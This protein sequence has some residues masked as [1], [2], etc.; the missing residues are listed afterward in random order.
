MPS[1]IWLS[2]DQHNN[3]NYY[4]NIIGHDHDLLP[5]CALGRAI[6]HLL[7]EWGRNAMLNLLYPSE[8]LSRVTESQQDHRPDPPM[9]EVKGHSV[10]NHSFLSNFG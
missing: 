1:Q 4:D 2:Q 10:R 8:V 9:G 3:P 5:L 7:R 6:Q